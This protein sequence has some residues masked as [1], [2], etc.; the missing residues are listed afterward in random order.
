MIEYTYMPFRPT[1]SVYKTWFIILLT[2]LLSGCATQLAPS[3][4]K[5]VVDGLNTANTESMTIFAMIS[6]GSS[7]PSFATRQ[8]KY[9][10]TIGKL[11]ALAVLAG[12][13]PM[14][15]NR[16][17]ETINKLLEK[18]GSGAISEDDGIPP[19]VFAIRKISETLSKCRNT[20]KQ[21]GVTALEAQAFKGQVLVF[22]DQALTYENFLQR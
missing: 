8:D 16:V 7:A 14:P 12:A 18:R 20:D 5:S 13:R 10:S 15:K 4:D 11:D 6:D 21:K 2:A 3:F 22:F 17:S 9:D 19:S 1:S